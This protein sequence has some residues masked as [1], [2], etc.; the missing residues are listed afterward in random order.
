MEPTSEVRGRE[1][2]NWGDSQRLWLY[3]AQSIY[4]V[5]LKRH[6]T[7]HMLASDDRRGSGHHRAALGQGEVGGRPEA[8]R[9]TGSPRSPAASQGDLPSTW[10]SG[11]PGVLL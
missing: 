9:P 7:Q 8:R 6:V 1:K 2:P 4:A 3:L 11:R 10:P 5:T